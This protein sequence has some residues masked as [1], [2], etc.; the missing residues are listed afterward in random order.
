MKRQT[1]NRNIILLVISSFTFIFQQLQ[2]LTAQQPTHYPKTDTEPVNFT[3]DNIILYIIIP[4][5][6]VLIYL[7]IKRY[8][9]KR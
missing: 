2:V 3:I 9:K 6:L 5:F 1:L 8:R 7:M 4:V